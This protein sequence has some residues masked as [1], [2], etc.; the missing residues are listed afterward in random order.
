MSSGVK[1]NCWRYIV[2]AVAVGEICFIA[3]GEDEGVLLC[4][5]RCTIAFILSA[6]LSVVISPL[7][8]AVNT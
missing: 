7:V 1:S 5:Y 6:L 8:T 3:A 4:C 2:P